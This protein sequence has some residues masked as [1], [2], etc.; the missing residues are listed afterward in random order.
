M[1]EVSR[2]VKKS[3]GIHLVC[4]AKKD[5]CAMQADPTHQH[6]LLGFVKKHWCVMQAPPMSIHL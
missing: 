3:W 1:Q 5:R 4:A 6:P 2:K